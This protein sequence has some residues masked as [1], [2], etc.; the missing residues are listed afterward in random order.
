MSGFG[1]KF[2]A[3]VCYVQ[4]T[5]MS[6][7]SAAKLYR[8]FES[9]PLRHAVW[10]AEK[11]RAT[12]PRNMRNMPI[13]RDSS[14]INWT[15]ENGLLSSNAVSIMAFLRKG[16]SGFKDSI[17][18]TQCDYKP[19]VRRKRVDF[20]FSIGHL[21]RPAPKHNGDMNVA[22]CPLPLGWGNMVTVIGRLR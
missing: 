4:L 2:S 21:T 17:R 18:R 1:V 16:A 7:L 12:F 20:G 19:V 3:Q 6:R 15:P 9:F 11:C 5:D 22:A 8:G 13:V 10:A 14:H